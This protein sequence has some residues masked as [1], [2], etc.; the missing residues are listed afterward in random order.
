MLLVTPSRLFLLTGGAL[1]ATCVFIAA[2]VGMLH[3]REKVRAYRW[4]AWFLHEHILG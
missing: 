3:W 1:L 2:L 4:I